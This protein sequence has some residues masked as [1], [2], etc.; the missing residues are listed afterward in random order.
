MSN[1]YGDSKRKISQIGLLEK[2][3]QTR[4]QF[5]KNDTWKLAK[6][7]AADYNIS[8]NA[9]PNR[10]CAHFVICRAIHA[11]SRPLP[12]QVASEMRLFIIIA[13]VHLDLMHCRRRPT[14]SMND[15]KVRLTHTA[16]KATK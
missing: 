14:P 16:P 6:I 13:T 1:Q 11:R 7:I 2:Q 9:L 3:D 8:Q 4:Q 10:C 15:G 5:S 12:C